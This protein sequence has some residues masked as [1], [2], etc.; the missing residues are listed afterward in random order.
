MC[1]LVY[2][3]LLKLQ[4]ERIVSILLPAMSGAPKTVPSIQQVL[5]R[6]E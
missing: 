6:F 5:S 3:L 4:E 1:L 2:Y